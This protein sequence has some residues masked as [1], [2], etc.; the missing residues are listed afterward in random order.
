MKILIIEDSAEIAELMK[1][2]LEEDGHE[3]LQARD[4]L[5]GMEAVWRSKPDLILLDIGLPVVDGLTV[6]RRLREGGNLLPVI[7]VTGR[8]DDS[9]VVEGLSA[10]ADDYICKPFSAKELRARVSA[11]SR[12]MKRESSELELRYEDLLLNLRNRKVTRAGLALE[13]TS[14]E[15][16]VIHLLMETPN[17]PIS[18]EELGLRLWG[19]APESSDRTVEVLMSRLRKKLDLPGLPALIVTSRSAGYSLGLPSLPSGVTP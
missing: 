5:A 6:L 13:L 2:G 4:G 1:L 18:R 15:F 3:V 11:L 16:A 17:K 19:R 10:G 8:I 9:D 12:R 14:R 7:M